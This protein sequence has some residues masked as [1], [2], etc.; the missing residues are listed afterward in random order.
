MSWP[1]SCHFKE[2]K[3]WHSAIK[4][5]TTK[6]TLTHSHTERNKKPFLDHLLLSSETNKCFQVYIGSTILNASISFAF[7]EEKFSIFKMVYTC[8]N[9][10]FYCF[11]KAV[12]KELRTLTN[13][14]QCSI[15]I[16]F[17]WTISKYSNKICIIH[18]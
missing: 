4:K 2:R 8:H 16:C 15:F 9:R 5:T 18:N 7:L 14:V 6:K 3:A 11:D 17:K 10:K 13:P 12:Q 1:Q